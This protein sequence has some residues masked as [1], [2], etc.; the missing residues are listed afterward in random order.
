MTP[1]CSKLWILL[2]RVRRTGP[3]FS[4]NAILLQ[5]NGYQ[6]KLQIVQRLMTAMILAT[7]MLLRLTPIRVSSVRKQQ[8]TSRSDSDCIDHIFTRQKLL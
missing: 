7:I 2:I 8:A 5:P 3:K 4:F 6:G 1:F